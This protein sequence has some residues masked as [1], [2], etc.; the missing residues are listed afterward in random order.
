MASGPSSRDP[1]FS[2]R[3]GGSQNW[4]SLKFLAVPLLGISVIL[5]VG[6]LITP[7]SSR[8]VSEVEE[9]AVEEAEFVD[10][11]SISRL[12]TPP[13]ETET[14]PS[15]LTPPAAATP[16]SPP[17]PAPTAPRGPDRY[18]DPEALPPEPVKTADPEDFSAQQEVQP[19]TATGVAP[20][21]QP[22]VQG[23]EVAEIVTR[24]TRGSG[25]SDFD[26]T[27]TSFPAVAFLTRRGIQDWSAQQQAC[28]FSEISADSYALAPRAVDVR[29]LTRNVEFIEQ[30]DVPRTFPSPTYQV[31]RVPDGYCGH[32]LFQVLQGGQS[33]LFIS[34]VG[35]GVGN[36]A[37][38]GLVVIWSS[39]P[40][41]G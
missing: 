41:L 14:P 29:Y 39:D 31:N 17:S 34:V 4:R 25:E 28:F 12:A 22:V 30:Q 2:S 13:P 3:V 16:T 7:L 24:L 18:P 1:G 15:P 8:P 37:G 33:L 40:R 35:V 32:T 6:L 27:A 21:A 36:P 20:V 26:S 10:L 11:L 19:N 38:T 5:H 23:P 9:S